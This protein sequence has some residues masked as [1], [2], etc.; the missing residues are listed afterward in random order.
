MNSLSR[1]KAILTRIENIPNI[2]AAGVVL[3]NKNF[4]CAA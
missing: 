4:I 3:A 1:Q 2:P